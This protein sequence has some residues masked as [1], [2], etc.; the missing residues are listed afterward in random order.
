MR[1]NRAA[2]VVAAVVLSA[3]AAF[4]GGEPVVYG[5]GLADAE[6]VPIDTLLAH[7]ERYVGKKV[8]VEGVV[9]DVCPRR[10][11]WI[12]IHDERSRAV[13]FEVE[14][15]EIVFPKECTGKDVT[16]EGVFRRME[17]DREQATAYL[18]HLAEERGEAFDPASV[19]GPLTL[20]RIEGSGAVVR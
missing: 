19:T 2:G 18:E 11:C 10:G 20:Y 5:A 3:S 13:R 12:D 7:P 15:G 6:P 14:D 16:A 8:R 4:G 9:A 1:N 17:L